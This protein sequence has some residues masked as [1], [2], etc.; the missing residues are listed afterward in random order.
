MEQNGFWIK[1]ADVKVTILPAVETKD[2]EKEEIKELADKIKEQIG[3]N[4]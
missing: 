1:P 4:L 2:M 3:N